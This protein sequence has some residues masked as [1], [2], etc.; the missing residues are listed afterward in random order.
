M[1]SLRKWRFP[2]LIGGGLIAAGIL[3]YFSN[4]H[5]SS[6]KTQGAIGK[7][8]VYRDGQV[9]SADVAAPGSAPVATQ[10]ILESSEFKALAK[11]KAF[12]ELLASNEFK[13]L[14]QKN[15]FGLLLSDPN[16]RLLALNP[17]FASMLHSS[18]FLSA[19]GSQSDISH[20]LQGTQFAD[21]ARS[22]PAQALF[23]NINFKS[24]ASEH[25]FGTL[26]GSA[27]FGSV[28]NNKSFALLASQASFVNA[29]QNGS[30]SRLAFGSSG[31]A[32]GGQPR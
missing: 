32:G 30:V 20:A 3:L 10:A 18:I 14:S 28:L 17:L 13:S 27:Y 5:V 24:I 21:L 6:D 15:A 22:A 9:D 11:D 26:V 4:T 31:V 29:L 1:S 23:A 12:Q 8:D 2:I 25:L 16:F 7:R 19:L